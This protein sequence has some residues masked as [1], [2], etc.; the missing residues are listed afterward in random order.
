MTLFEQIKKYLSL[1]D[2]NYKNTLFEKGL[3]ED[4]YVKILRKF[5]EDKRKK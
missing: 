2:K 1:I 4:E 5:F 3:Y